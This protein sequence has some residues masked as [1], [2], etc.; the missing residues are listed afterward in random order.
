MTSYLRLTYLLL[1]SSISSHQGSL[2]VWQKTLD[3]GW[4]PGL[5][6]TGHIGPVTDLDWYQSV[7][8]PS[9]HFSQH[10]LPSS[11]TALDEHDPIGITT[12]SLLLS[13]SADQ[14]VRIHSDCH[15][16]FS[17]HQLSCRFQCRIVN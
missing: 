15:H 5:P 13:C 6:L 2:S 8:Q 16:F 4:V 12:G 3:S 14:T 10:A 1:F 9:G 17:L 7:S 11:E